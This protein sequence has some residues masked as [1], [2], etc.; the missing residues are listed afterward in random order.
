[1][2][3]CM[4]FYLLIIIQVNLPQKPANV[5]QLLTTHTLPGDTIWFSWCGKTLTYNGQITAKSDL[6]HRW[7]KE[8]RWVC[9]TTAQWGTILQ[10]QIGTSHDIQRVKIT[11]NNTDLADQATIHCPTSWWNCVVQH[12]KGTLATTLGVSV[13]LLHLSVRDHFPKN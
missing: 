7:T 1:M 5:W 9:Q 11:V 8:H 6:L 4:A 13:F 2:L 10:L 3:L 12:Y